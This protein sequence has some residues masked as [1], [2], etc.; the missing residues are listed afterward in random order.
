[1]N[2]V[3]KKK[4]GQSGKT[5]RTWFA[6]E[7]YRITWRREVFGVQIPAR[8]QAAVRVEIPCYNREEPFVMWD[9]VSK[10][11]LY[12]TLN[13]AQDDCERH[14]QL[15]LSACEA[16]GP[17]ALHD[18]FGKCLPGGI[19]VWVKKKINR[20]AYAVLLEER[21]AQKE[22]ECDSN[23]NDLPGVSLTTSSD[24]SSAPFPGPVS[25]VADVDGNLPVDVPPATEVEKEPRKPARKRTAKLSKGTARKAVSTKGLS[26]RGR[27]RSKGSRKCKSKPSKN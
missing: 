23:P 18:I 7:G 4:R 16:N 26:K 11:R 3:R 9:F 6:K 1:M 2:F 21:R 20:K 25:S 27:P 5:R 17:R 24:T 15:W 13:A 19:P 14:Q 10:R 8:F 12:K 22:D